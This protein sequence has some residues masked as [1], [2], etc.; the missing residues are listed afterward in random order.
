MIA[1]ME[2]ERLEALRRYGVLDTPPEHEFDELAGLAS[3][4][5]RTPFA[6]ISLIDADRQWFKATIGL[7]LTEVPRTQ[8]I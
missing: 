6:A 8:S 2:T 5:C 4:I 7:S 1:D 3:Q